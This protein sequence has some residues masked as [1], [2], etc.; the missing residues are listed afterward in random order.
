MLK[1]HSIAYLAARGGPA[2][3]SFLTIAVLTRL[4]TTD[5]YGRYQLVKASLVTPVA[6]YRLM[7]REAYRDPGTYRP[8]K[9]E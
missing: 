1:R 6:S 8:S 5:A 2:I 4:M 3:V 7:K 9:M